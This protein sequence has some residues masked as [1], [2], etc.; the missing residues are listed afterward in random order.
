MPAA[1]GW[2]AALLAAHTVSWQAVVI[3]V[4]AMLAGLAYRLLAERA[5][6]KTLL[7]ALRAPARTVVILGDGPGGPPMWVRVGDAPP[8]AR[9]EPVIWVCHQSAEPA[10]SRR[11]A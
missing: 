1:P 4:G 11:H 6:R 2:T 8:P 3:V 9:P 5:R 7:A 10:R